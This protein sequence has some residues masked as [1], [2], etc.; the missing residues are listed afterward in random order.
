MQTTIDFLS[1]HISPEGEEMD[2][3]KVEV[4][5]QWQP[6]QWVKDMQCL[7]W[8]TNY[9]QAFVPHFVNPDLFAQERGKV[10]MGGGGARS[11]Q[12]HQGHL[13]F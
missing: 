12:S 4:L 7:L 10:S 2:Q 5:Q 9:F 3:E 8:F 13:C 11:L 1:Y 6:P